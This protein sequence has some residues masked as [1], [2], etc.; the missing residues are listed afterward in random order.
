[1]PGSAGVVLEPT[2]GADKEASLPRSTGCRPAA[3]PRAVKAS[4]RPTHLAKQNFDQSGVN[5]VILAT[6]GD[7]NVGITDPNAARGLRRREARER[8]VSLSVLGFGGGNLQRPL[9]QK[10]A[11][12]GNGTAAYIDT[13]ERGAQGAGGRDVLDA[14]HDRQRR[15]DPGRVQSRARR[16]VPPHR[17]RDAAAA[18][19]PTSTTTRSTPAM[20]APATR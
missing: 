10:L 20:S 8:R 3:R 14:L 12:A 11:Q 5:R 6:D 13:R 2:R 9:M 18:T 17:L 19:R 7:F 1:M 4:V 15:E 16:R